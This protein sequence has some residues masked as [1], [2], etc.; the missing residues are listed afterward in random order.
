MAQKSKSKKTKSLLQQVCHPDA[1]GI[2][3]GATEF[4]AAISKERAAAAGE[5]YSV[6]IF[7]TFNCGIAAAITWLKVHEVKT[8]AMESTGNY[9]V[10][11]YDQLI[12]AKFDVFLVNA[13]HCKALPGRKTDV[14]D[15]QWIQQLHTSGLLRKSFLPEDDFRVI[16]YLMRHR[17]GLIREAAR[18]IQRMQKVL[19]QMNVQLH[20]AISDIDGLS[21]RAIIEAILAGERDPGTLADL[22]HPSCKTPR[23]K[24]M[25][26]L[27]GN[28][29]D[30]YL[31][32]LGQDYRR[33]QRVREEI[34]EAERELSQ[35]LAACP[36]MEPL[37]SA[38][39]PPAE[40]TPKK[41][42]KRKPRVYKLSSAKGSR[43]NNLEVDFQAQA[44]R[45]YGVDLSTIPGVSD[46]VLAALLAE[47]GGRD[48][49]LKNFT[50][51]SRF[52]SWLGQCPDNRITG[53]RVKRAKT[54]SVDSPL[55]KALRLAAMTL[56][57]NK[58]YLGDYCRKMKARLGKPEGITAT[59]HKLARVIY[60]MIAT[61]QPFDE[62]IGQKA[63][64]ETLQRQI[65]NLAKKAKKLGMTLTM[66]TF[67]A[68]IS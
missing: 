31:F 7:S 28:F 52:T 47:I 32:V 1:A 38:E 20:H 19:V 67:N 23:K 30:E 54:R 3:L 9:W 45:I 22:R 56:W 51:V 15:A 29:R 53:G 43:K 41:E 27:A 18:E 61:G 25:A 4:Y 49:F 62:S 8:V 58:S 36:G 42:P 55:A 59:A 26:A 5:K 24:V 34:A 33:W 35:R 64:E 14:C 46:G 11:L 16:R 44:A 57:R 6:K 37:P 13:S 40:S 68:A 48:E 66:S 17:D 60:A 39:N 2:D 10:A 21:G 63:S 50:S 65:N 12:T